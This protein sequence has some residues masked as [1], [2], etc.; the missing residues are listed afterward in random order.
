MIYDVALQCGWNV[1]LYL[2]MYIP[3]VNLKHPLFLCTVWCKCFLY[4]GSMDL[5]FIILE[6]I[7][8]KEDF[9]T[10]NQDKCVAIFV[11]CMKLPITVKTSAII[12]T[13]KSTFKFSRMEPPMF[14]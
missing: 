13:S 12:S 6:L 14:Y 9:D 10:W 7:T 4:S 2:L 8:R 5:D 1:Q 11:G 3:R